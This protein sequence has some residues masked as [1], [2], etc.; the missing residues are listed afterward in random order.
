MKIKFLQPAKEDIKEIRD[1]YTG[2]ANSKIAK[3]I[4]DTIKE[5]IKRLEQFPESGSDTPY[6]ELNEQGYKMVIS[7][8]NYVSIYRIIDSIIY[9]YHVANTQTEYI[10]LF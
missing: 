2:R 10:D 6:E 3:K 7:T 5:S 8:N 9:I 1:Y 4:T